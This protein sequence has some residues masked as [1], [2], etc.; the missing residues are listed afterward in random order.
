M[1][2]M[3]PEA[4]ATRARLLDA[5][6]EEFAQHGVAGARVD[7]VAA[8]AGLNKR[9]IYVHFGNKEQ[10]FEAVTGEM[11]GVLADAVPFTPDDLPGYAGALFDHLLRHPRQLRLA[12]WQQ[13][14]RPGLAEAAAAASYRPKVDAL[15]ARGTP[16]HPADVLTL[17]LALTGAWLTA[18]S[19]LRALAPQG[20]G[21]AAQASPERVAA[22]RAAVVAAVRALVDDERNGAG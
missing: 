18:P 4:A 3:S 12:L 14:E 5:A 19:A 1:G 8:R 20:E 11:V 13:L 16:H 9:L 6:F 10:L 22:H 2:V 21:E 7:R 15:A 17:V